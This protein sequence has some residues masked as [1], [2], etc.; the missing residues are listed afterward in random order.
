M[1]RNEAGEFLLVRHTYTPGW[2]FPGGGVEKGR[3]AIQA[4]S[5][6]VA[7][8]TG[9][10]LTGIPELHGLF[11]NA[12]VSKT[13][14]VL[15]YICQVEE[16]LTPKGDSLEIAQVCFFS[17]DSI[18]NQIDRGTLRRIREITE[19]LRPSETWEP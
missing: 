3:T 17:L 14:H 4:L 2:H 6:E 10:R 9:L 19:G 1:I 18:P 13:D 16:G 7:Q 11:H 15:V 8:E 12:C 5:K